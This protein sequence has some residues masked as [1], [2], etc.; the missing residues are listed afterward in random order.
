MGHHP[1]SPAS[2]AWANTL[3]ALHLHGPPEQSQRGHHSPAH[4]RH[5]EAHHSDLHQ[6]RSLRDRYR[7]RRHR[8]RTR[9]GPKHGRVRRG[10]QPLHPCTP[11]LL[12]WIH[13]A[14]GPPL[15]RQFRAPLPVLG[16]DRGAGTA[17]LRVWQLRGPRN[18]CATTT[19]AHT[20]HTGFAGEFQPTTAREDSRDLTST[21]WN[22]GRRAGSECQHAEMTARARGGRSGGIVGRVPAST[23]AGMAYTFLSSKKGWRLVKSVHNSTPNLIARDTHTSGVSTHPTVH[24]SRDHGSEDARVN[25]CRGSVALGRAASANVH[26]F[27]ASTQRFLVRRA[28]YCT[29]ATTCATHGAMY[30]GVPLFVV[31]DLE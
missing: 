1:R 13:R 31:M 7:R 22:D 3:M 8:N 29:P 24:A 28:T 11:P 14:P 4:T 18:P 12:R 15:H 26:G 30:A 2:H 10:R 23:A 5:E 20:P 21:R 27:A 16:L 9:K 17:A 25:V 19:P 6:S